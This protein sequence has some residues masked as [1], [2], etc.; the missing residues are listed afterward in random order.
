VILAP[1][2][3]GRAAWLEINK[4]TQKDRTANQEV[5]IIAAS[6]NQSGQVFFTVLFQAQPGTN[7][8][9]FT[10]P[11]TWLHFVPKQTEP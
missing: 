4:Q 10:Y 7:K 6:S 2:I 5:T 11:A 8:L 9:I 1:N 3:L